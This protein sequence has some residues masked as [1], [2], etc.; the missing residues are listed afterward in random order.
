MYWSGACVGTCWTTPLHPLHVGC[1]CACMSPG[2][3]RLSRH[4]YRVS[5]TSS[6]SR[7][8]MHGMFALTAAHL[9][10]LCGEPRVDDMLER[11]VISWLS[12]PQG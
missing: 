4:L 3:E 5:H 10:A 2:W 1:C 9:G 11:M 8:P 6:A 12:W 7:V